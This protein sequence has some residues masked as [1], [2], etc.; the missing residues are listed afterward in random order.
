MY[1]TTTQLSLTTTNPSDHK[2][3]IDVRYLVNYGR[4]GP[5]PLTINKEQVMKYLASYDYESMTCE[6]IS[7]LL[8]CNPEPWY[9]DAPK[10]PHGIPQVQMPKMYCLELATCSKTDAGLTL[11]FKGSNL[12]S[13]MLFN[14]FYTEEHMD[15]DFLKEMCEQYMIED[16]ILDECPNLLSEGWLNA[17]LDDTHYDQFS[18]GQTHDQISKLEDFCAY[19]K[20]EEVLARYNRMTDETV[21]AYYG[22]PVMGRLKD[23]LK[24]KFS[25]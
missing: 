25:S 24:Q 21:R 18:E 23:L 10:S 1:T 8:K 11:I 12:N 2:M 9:V 22:L 20:H 19:V 17:F 14:P 16:R 6:E 4:Y 3:I 7:N 13:S 15:E 5:V